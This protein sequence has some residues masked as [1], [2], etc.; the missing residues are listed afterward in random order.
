M[1]SLFL[2]FALLIFSPLAVSQQPL[3]NNVLFVVSPA[4]SDTNPGTVERPFAT[5]AKALDATRKLTGKSPAKVLLREGVYFLPA[6]LVFKPEDS[7]NENA[8]ASWEAWPGESPVLSAGRPV[9]G[10]RIERVRNMTLWVADLKGKPLQLWVNGKR[11]ARPRL[12]KE[13]TYRMAEVPDMK[14][15]T[16][17]EEGQTRFR[18]NEGDIKAWHN[19]EDIDVVALHFW[20][21]SRMPIKSVDEKQ[22]LVELGRRSIFRLSDD[23]TKALARYWVE[24]VF[25]ALDG[26]GQWYHDRKAGKVYYHPRPGEDISGAQVIA[27]NNTQAIRIEGEPERGRF[28]EYLSF[29][30]LT[31]SHGEASSPSAGWPKPDSAG[32]FQA[33][34]TSPGLFYA[35]GYRNGSFR[36]GRIANTGSYALEL[37]AGCTKIAIE[38]NVM[39]DLGAGGVKIGEHYVHKDG[40][41]RTGNITVTDNEIHDGGQVFPSGVGVWIGQSGGNLV[42]HNNIHDFYYTGVSVG[43]SWGY[44][45][46]PAVNNRIE[47][48]HIHRL[49]KGVLSDMAGVYTLGYSPGTVIRNNVIHDITS[50]T[51]GGFGIYFDE[52]STGIVAEKNVVYRC[53]SHCFHQHSGNDNTLRNNV[54]AFGGNAQIARHLSEDLFSLKMERNIFYWEG[55]PLLAGDWGGRQFRWENNFFWNPAGTTGLPNE[56]KAQGLDVGSQ[57]LNPGFADPE[58]GNFSLSPN[59]PALRSGFQPIDTSNVGPRSPAH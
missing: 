22:R 6:P 37:S 54:F 47:F 59:S 5:P 41:M 55:G 31:F 19:L 3:S 16:P 28:V 40:R 18:F 7:G 26:P 42:A 51:Y 14:P 33:A 34:F 49:G 10:W 56:W 20:V 30:G 11:A 24:N 52:G 50:N 48:N 25:E 58:R 38:H 36:K 39:H 4:G 32:P 8:P 53:N 9:S 13:G 21:D 45:V 43:W 35:K 23:Y 17:R 2:T 1:K 29:S 57:V 12:P 46:A 44:K 15:G 27:S